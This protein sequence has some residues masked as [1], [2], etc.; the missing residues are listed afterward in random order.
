MHLTTEQL[1][2]L[3]DG[4]VA[5][6]PGRHLLQC[7]ECA[8][9]V[10]EMAALRSALR[11][12]PALEPPAV[13][14]EGI[15][16][17]HRR[18]RLVWRRRAWAAALAALLVMAGTAG[19]VLRPAAT[20]PPEVAAGSPDDL[21][22]LMSASRELETVLRS[23]SLRSPVLRP[24]EAARIVVLE[25][26]L[27]LVDTQLVTVQAGPSRERALA[28]WSDRVELLDQLVRVRGRYAGGGDFQYATYD[29]ERSAP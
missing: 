25:D 3:R 14:W 27:A 4:E 15:L 18:R 10:E 13:A 28:L 2:A 6:E 16:A 11:G 26:Q 17:E 8:R 29:S 19:L 21:A 5:P 23:P 7:P 12:L 22:D 20:R 1:L 9:R 24:A